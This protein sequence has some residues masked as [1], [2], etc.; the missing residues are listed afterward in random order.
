MPASKDAND[1]DLPNRG[2]DDA[3]PGS[4]D[5]FIGVM[6]NDDACPCPCCCE[7]VVAASREVELELCPV[8]DTLLIAPVSRSGGN[9][10][11][12]VLT[13]LTNCVAANGVLGPYGCGLTKRVAITANSWPV[14]A[15]TISSDEEINDVLLVGMGGTVSGK[16]GGAAD[17]T[18]TPCPC[19]LWG[20]A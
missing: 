15:A 13:W 10:T 9:G 5:A 20:T 4:A 17:A 7:P 19:N 16:A 12:A 6:C 14:A 3:G 1:N 2:V 11:D 18:D 8:T